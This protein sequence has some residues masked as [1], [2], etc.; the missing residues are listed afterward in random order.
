MNI[1]VLGALSHLGVNFIRKYSKY[2]KHVI[3]VD[4]V[5]YCS[6]SK[7]IINGYISKFIE[8]DIVEADLENIIVFHSIS[9]IL[10][11]AA[12]THVDR[13]YTHFDEFINDNINCVSTIMNT[14]V[15][16][17]KLKYEV[18]MIHLSTDEVYGDNY[19][20][21]R[22]ETDMLNPTNPYSA[23]K[24]SGDMI[25]NSYCNSYNL[26]KDIIVLRPNNM[27]GCFQYPDKVIPLFIEKILNNETVY[28]HGNGEQKR[29]FI[30]TKFVSEIIFT[31]FTMSNM[32]D[33]ELF[34]NVGF[35]DQSGL[36]VNSV[37]KTIKYTLVELNAIN[38]TKS[39]DD[40]KYPI[41]SNDR[42]YNDKIY[43]ISNEKLC[44]FLEKC[45]IQCKEDKVNKV[46]DTM[47]KKVLYK[48][49]QTSLDSVE[50]TV[51]SIINQKKYPYQSEL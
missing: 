44:N 47:I 8:I 24:A 29:C 51:K 50:N 12:S 46:V 14:M 3:A 4:K 22:C 18:K 33:D 25:I 35:N 34:Y 16:L 27:A 40:L 21:L 13:S 31:L 11:T 30:S 36:S 26:F 7:E 38:Y 5:S 15:S 9:L 28:I 19:D 1:L 17:K 39:I 45:S 2:F 41:F 48:M 42:P 10:N 32:W 43:K 49:N 20:T 23:S 6:Q 37:Y